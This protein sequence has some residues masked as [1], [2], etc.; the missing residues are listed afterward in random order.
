MASGLF[1]RR[2]ARRIRVER[3]KLQGICEAHGQPVI[4]GCKTICKRC[5]ENQRKTHEK[6]KLRRL[7]KE[8][9]LNE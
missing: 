3:F 2:R 6:R 9:F 5:R 8:N 4:P 1:S 7:I